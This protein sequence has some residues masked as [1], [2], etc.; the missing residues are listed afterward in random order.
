MKYISLLRGINVSGKNKIKMDELK[1][2]YEHIGFEDVSTYIQSGNV[3][4]TTDIKNK[5]ELCKTIEVAIKEK[6]KFHVPVVLRTKSEIL[7]II[8]SC[9]FGS[10]DI[11]NEGSKILVTLLS[12]LPAKDSLE[13][14]TKFV[15][16]T[17]KL[18]LK[19][20]EVYLYCPNGYG[21]S[22]LSNNFLEKKLGVSATTRNWKSLCK[23]S[24]L[25][26]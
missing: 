9:P 13:N 20:K 12:S 16:D 2:L 11:E 14:I 1:S 8:K 19:D 15:A 23:I 10:V 17:E 18:V 26:N 21:K 22:K 3:I 24:D 6:Y 25:L 5:N 4:F 7:N